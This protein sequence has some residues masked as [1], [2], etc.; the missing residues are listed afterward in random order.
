MYHGCLRQVRCYDAAH[1]TAM[2]L[3]GSAGAVFALGTPIA[4]V[5]LLR[6]RRADLDSPPFFRAFGFMYVQVRGNA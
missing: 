3:A 5:I 6:R 4:N 1:V 2:L